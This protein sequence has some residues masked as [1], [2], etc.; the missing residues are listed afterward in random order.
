VTGRVWICIRG[1]RA[2]SAGEALASALGQ[3]FR[4]SRSHSRSFWGYRLHLACARVNPSGAKR[5]H[6]RPLRRAPQL[7]T[8]SPRPDQPLEPASPAGQITAATSGAPFAARFRCSISRASNAPRRVAPEPDASM[9][10][11][12]QQIA[13]ALV[14]VASPLTGPS[15]RP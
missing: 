13:Q 7:P 10:S 15:A 4:D 14:E 9:L 1:W 6:L 3:T 12:G 2:E 11:R 8:F 5:P